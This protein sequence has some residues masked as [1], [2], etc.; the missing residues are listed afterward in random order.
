VGTRPS[1]ADDLRAFFP[2]LIL[3]VDYDIT[4]PATDVYN[5]VGW[6]IRDIHNWWEPPP[7]GEW[8]TDRLPGVGDLTESPAASASGVRRPL[9]VLVLVA[10]LIGVL[11]SATPAGST[12]NGHGCE[13]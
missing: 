12:A 3:G 1:P 4:S 13:S 8:P 11:I 7:V 2:N 9:A 6:V 10:V 5:C